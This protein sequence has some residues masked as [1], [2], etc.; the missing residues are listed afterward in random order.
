MRSQIDIDL[1]VNLHGQIDVDE[2]IMAGENR[3]RVK[4]LLLEK[5]LHQ[6]EGAL[7]E[8]LARQLGVETVTP[9][10]MVAV[11][12][13]IEQALRGGPIDARGPLV[14]AH[15]RLWRICAANEGRRKPI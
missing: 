1:K 10:D 7:R 14:E 13:L 11:R 4:A 5:M 6:V 8:S 3:E 9:D 2:T 12:D 15:Y